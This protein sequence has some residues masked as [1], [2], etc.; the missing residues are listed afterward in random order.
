[1]SLKN[2]IV[3]LTLAFVSV[4]HV[5]GQES[6]EALR[7][8][9]EALFEQEN[10]PEA[11]PI[12]SQLLSLKLQSPEYNYR[13]GA[14]QLFTIQNKEEPLKYLDFAVKAE[15]P[16]ALAYF[17]Y[18]LGLHLNYRFDKAIEQYQKYK[19]LGATKDKMFKLADRYI[20]QCTDGKTLVSSFTDISVVEAQ[21][22]PRR[23]FYR[24]YDL[25]EF[26]GKII[27][28]PDDFMS[29]EDKKRD[30][31]FLMYFQE[32][33][34]LIY[35][36]SYS[37]KNATG[38]DLYYIQK[39]PT[40]GWSTPSKL[41]ATI[42]T[43]YDEDYPFIHPE[44]DVLYFASKG[45]NSMGG[46]DI[47]KSTRRG[48]GTW[49]QPE[50]MEFAI[51]TPWDEFMFISDLD[52]K[53]AWF[54]S[55]RETSNHDVTLYKIGIDRVPLDLT[56]I[57][58]NFQAEGSRKAK[59]TVQ[60]LTQ[61]K[62]VGVYHSERQFGEYIL[63]LRGSGKY[64][65]IVEA[66][67]SNS[68]HEGIVEIPREKGLKQ[69]KQEMI[70][71]VDGGEEKLQII[72]H[73]DEELDSDE[74]LLTA[75]ILRRQA[76][77]TVNSSED[78]VVRTTEIL[79][80]GVASSGSVTEG[81]SQEELIAE[82][83][84]L[85]SE[86]EGD[87]KLLNQKAAYL[88]DV[89][90]E[91]QSSSDPEQV[92]EGA[93]AA[94]LAG[95][96]KM[97]ADNRGTAADR[98]NGS[99]S[100]LSSGALEEAAF[101][102]QF[103][104]LQVTSS[105]Y[106][107]LSKFEDRVPNEFERRIAPTL[108]EYEV[109]VEEVSTLED[110]LIEL[111]KEIEY[112]TSEKENTKDETM[113]AEYQAQID[114]AQATKPDKQA[115]HDRATAELDVLED[116]KDKASNYF[117]IAKSLM[118]S[119]DAGA[120]GVANLV[121]AASIN[122]IQIAF[123][124]GAENNPALLAMI[125]PTLAEG[126]LAQS[127]AAGRKEDSQSSEPND[128]FNA[129][130]S[131]AGTDEPASQG[132]QIDEPETTTEQ[133]ADEVVQSS[134]QDT[135]VNDQI[136]QIVG[137]ESEP[138]IVSGD[139]NAF[140]NTEVAMAGNAED[141]V[142]A[143][144]RKAELY[145]QWVDNLQFRI[146]SL[147]GVQQSEDL[148]EEQNTVINDQ[149]ASLE[150]TK[151]EK[152]DLSLNSYQRIAELSDQASSSESDGGGDGQISGVDSPGGDES[153]GSGTEDS[154]LVDDNTPAL[155]LADFSTDALPVKVIRLNSSYTAQLDA[156]QEPDPI[157]QKKAQ[158]GVYQDWADELLGQLT[159]IQTQRDATSS[160]EEQN[161]LDQKATEVSDLRLEKVAAAAKLNQE[162]GDAEFAQANIGV[163][164]N[165]QEQLYQYVDNYDK[166]AFDQIKT[167]IENGT[168]QE[169][170]DAQ[171]TTLNKNW[172]MAIQNEKVKLEARFENTDDPEQIR[173]IEDQ[174][175]KLITEK[176]EVQADLAALDP[177]AKVAE[178]SAPSSILVEGA[179]RFEGYEPVDNPTV[180]NYRDVSAM[181]AASATDV[182][183]SINALETELAGTKKKKH[184]AEIEDRIVVEEGAEAVAEMRSIF[185]E[186]A[187]EIL[188]TT[189]SQL[190]QLGPEDPLPSTKQARVAEDLAME[191]TMAAN[192]AAKM[193]E[194]ALNIRKKK[195]R[196]AAVRD[197]QRASNDATVK[198]QKSQL[199]AQLVEDIKSVEQEAVAQNFLILPKD[200][201][202]LP[203][204]RRE[205]NP[206]E[207]ADV[208][209]TSEFQYYES[210]RAVA[211]SI[212]RELKMIEMR[213]EQFTKRGQATM[214]QSAMINS[215]DDGGRSRMALAEQAYADFETADSLS[216]EAAK[217][218]RQAT[219]YENE[220]NRKLLM[221]PE[222]VYMNIIAYYNLNAVNITIDTSDSSFAMTALPSIK[223]AA[224]AE[225]P[226][227]PFNLNAPILGGNE[228][229]AIREDDKL[230][231]TIF[232]LNPGGNSS[233]YSESN[234]IP[235]DPPKPPGV[236]YKVQIGAFK[237]EIPQD[238]FPGIVPIE[239][240]STNFGFTRYTAGEF[241]AFGSA[242]NAKIRIRSAGYSDAFVVA[243]RDG[244]RISVSQARGGAGSVASSGSGTGT[245]RVSSSGSSLVQQ[246]STSITNVSEIA[247]MFY[248]VQVGVYSRPV[249]PNEIYN[250][251]PL[252]QENLSNGTYRYTT[253]VFDNEGTATRARDEVRSLGISDA[254][255]TAYRSGQRITM[256][257]A[258]ESSG[259]FATQ[260]SGGSSGPWSYQVLLGTYT[261]EV[262]VQDAVV[263]LRLSSQGVDKVSNGDGSSSYYYGAFTN[264]SEADA[265]A[266]R[267]RGQ[268]MTQ[269]KS[270]E[271]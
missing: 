140:F 125:A 20:K 43:S 258:R 36:A 126:A 191:A 214:A 92:A 261:G 159:A 265:E 229:V 247:G 184:R 41:P 199:S 197:A 141:P 86:M 270:I 26:G 198:Q 10:F 152:L 47:F 76:S 138:E 73:F 116:S 130:A 260:P 268:G 5:S 167:G 12:Y 164:N 37:D 217:L 13:F 44:G 18:G 82:A 65:F 104:Q 77:L 226:E 55:N 269:A 239:G 188:A 230:T 101:N 23:E 231:S 60:D 150:S 81:K 250:I 147:E 259:G 175:A 58:G 169:E 29:D 158:A 8:K 127:V 174:L 264:S 172:L 45:H 154:S 3:A 131:I 170:K 134:D 31:R 196:I 35:Y 51:N 108:S 74:T 136:Q 249:R 149:L 56:L 33:A 75:D 155:S 237:R 63:D 64:K 50:N 95:V 132:T 48:D 15:E 22:L 204:T 220:A 216:S 78:E 107:E 201:I 242:D 244:V 145:D 241:K 40:G 88:Y 110:D 114:E 28:K 153:T 19:E 9:A 100:T 32:S 124:T 119:A 161:I 112:L 192:T 137:S 80:D 87:A 234:P 115:S 235:I 254:F 6:E 213:E 135:D 156:V 200:Q 133:P 183:N 59:I 227:D 38:K 221:E 24:N 228:P 123:T 83:T 222:E 233:S 99:L 129:P 98:M 266:E 267:L 162:A 240:E 177:D 202:T 166:R 111:D 53:L 262:P 193:M 2:H 182:T 209:A 72:N 11:F 271:R 194:D 139:Y 17:Y 4:L 210:N 68:I 118:L 211:D 54:A 207:Q 105:N 238:A 246:G 57:K 219:F 256:N 173:Y 160:I 34:D 236:I 66:Q 61:N 151:D 46:Y 171:L 223:E 187:A 208:K 122:T 49:T 69:F 102:A 179:E 163:Q 30:A 178:L 21:V 7:E 120:S 113:Q 85:T 203:M 263:I 245:G 189:E 180:G 248:T 165:L 90:V 89:A 25:R 181:A 206:T 257:E 243:Y 205:L 93:I 176:D 67:E 27:V 255:V 128:T 218:K 70:L 190:L 253:G 1:M 14:C 186:E 79:D 212:R 224:E 215:G 94:E 144:T 97:E 252:N 39:L 42:N 142:I 96:Y 225:E 52:E 109:K 91:K 117:T 157:D 251:S 106:D 71:A 146:D 148:S 103:N 168:N 121:T 62:I 195:V 232:E 16:P 84:N 185:Y 143:E